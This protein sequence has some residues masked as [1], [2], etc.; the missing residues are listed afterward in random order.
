[1]INQQLRIR[2]HAPP[3]KS[4]LLSAV[5]TYLPDAW[6]SPS[7]KELVSLYRLRYKM[8][9]DERKYDS[10]LIFLNKVLE[11]EPLNLEAKLSKAELY[12]RHL[13]DYGSAVENYN[14]VI[15]LSQQ[16]PASAVHLKARESLS[17]LMEM[18]S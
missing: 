7:S 1:M 4:R 6:F 10:A 9:L 15:R 5:M 14:K 16:T 3:A 17:E 13:N 11:V 18:L 12:H 8:A 2:R